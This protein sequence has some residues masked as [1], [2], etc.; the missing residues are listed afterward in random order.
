MKTSKVMQKVISKLAEKHGLDLTAPETHLRLDMQG[1]DRLVI[2]KI[3]ARLV[4]VG[5]F[6]ESHGYLMADPE[7]VFFIGDTGW[8]PIEITQALGGRRIYADL[9][10]DGQEVALVSPLD[11]MALALFAEGWARNIEVQGWLEHG[12][13]WTAC[14]PDQSETPDLET[15]MTWVMGDTD[16]QATD[17]CQVDLDGVC[18][19][20]CPS[21][22]VE[23]GLI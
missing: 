9:S 7:I 12:E 8:I 13:K 20:G 3:G 2:A 22:L 14:Q 21:W 10:S 11:Q 18:S 15:L 1:F 19:H 5:H 17:G 23:L 4:S 16:C 6:F